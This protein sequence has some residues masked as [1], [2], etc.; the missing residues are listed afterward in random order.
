MPTR[1]IKKQSR[2]ES[3]SGRTAPNR[4]GSPAR[5]KGNTAKELEPVLTSRKGRRPK[6]ARSRLPGL[7]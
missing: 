5:D 1:S 4:L 7:E 6:S 2:I 3:A